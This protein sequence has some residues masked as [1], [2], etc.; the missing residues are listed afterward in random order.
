MLPNGPAEAPCHPA[1]LPQYPVGAANAPPGWPYGY[2]IPCPPPYPP[3]ICPKPPAMPS[4][5]RHI[6]PQPPYMPPN[7]RGCS[8]A[9]DGVSGL[10]EE[11]AY[12]WRIRAMV[13]AAE[14]LIMLAPLGRGVHSA[15]DWPVPSSSS[16][17]KK[18]GHI[19]SFDTR[20]VTYG[21]RSQRT[22]HP[23]RSAIHKLR[24]GRLVLQWVTVR[25]SRLLYVLFCFLCCQERMHS[26]NE[27]ERL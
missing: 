6:P 19:Y 17:S 14:T 13:A 9:V 11:V 10:A 16:A 23:V 24:I 8:A 12:R 20:P 25:E 21:Q 2:P 18:R 7:E 27:A 4:K 22:G 1:C 3:N 15:G 5:L 26:R